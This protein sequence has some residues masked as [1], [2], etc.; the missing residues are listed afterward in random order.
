MP[1]HAANSLS[2]ARFGSVKRLSRA[3][4][5]DAL[6]WRGDTPQTSSPN[7]LRSAVNPLAEDSADAWLVSEAGGAPGVEGKLAICAGVL[8]GAY[9]V[10][11]TSGA[12][13]A[14]SRPV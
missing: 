1:S 13:K 3:G 2:V 10:L 12:G 9:E 8:A 14:V 4:S 7:Q 11:A 6:R 5:V